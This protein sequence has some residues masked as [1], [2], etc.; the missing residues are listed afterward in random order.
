MHL[1]VLNQ[2]NKTADAHII[3]AIGTYPHVHW[4][5][6]LVNSTICT[7][8]VPFISTI[9]QSQDCHR[10]LVES[11]SLLVSPRVVDG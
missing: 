4:S 10:Y 11:T 8:D 5:N 6:L 9:N 3:Y 1:R 7:G 2:F